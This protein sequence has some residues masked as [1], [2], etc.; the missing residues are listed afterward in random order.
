MDFLDID[1]NMYHS[2]IEVHSKGNFLSLTYLAITS[3]FVSVSCIQTE[4]SLRIEAIS[5]QGF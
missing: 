5:G 1:W 4:F 3:R 2:H